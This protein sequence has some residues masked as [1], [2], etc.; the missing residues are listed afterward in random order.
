MEEKERPKI[1]ENCILVGTKPF[2][3]Y[4]KSVNTL[5]RGKN[6]SEIE[7]RARGKNIKKAIDIAESSRKK[8]CHDLNLKIKKIDID[9]DS[10]TSE[11]GREINVSTITIILER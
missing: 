10:F 4:M 1:P 7:I 9:T 2:M 5:F 6:L 8:F 3:A 11:E